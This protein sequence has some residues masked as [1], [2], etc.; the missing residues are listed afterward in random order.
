MG[1][2]LSWNINS[3]TTLKLETNYLKSFHFLICISIITHLKG[4][5]KGSDLIHPIS[6]RF[7]DY[8]HCLVLFVFSVWIICTVVIY[9]VNVPYWT[10]FIGTESLLLI[11]HAANG[12]FT[13]KSPNVE[14]YLNTNNW[15]SGFLGGFYSALFNGFVLDPDELNWVQQSYFQLPYQE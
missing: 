9:N 11:L 12:C 6:H 5:S 8:H 13:N 10:P 2:F 15:G 3:I 4:A 7:L 1:L 14:N